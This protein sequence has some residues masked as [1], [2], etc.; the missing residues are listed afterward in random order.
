ME[1]AK[2]LNG[3]TYV[4]DIEKFVRYLR[5]KSDIFVM[6]FN[7]RWPMRCYS[8]CAIAFAGG[9]S[10]EPLRKVGCIHVL[11]IVDLTEFFLVAMLNF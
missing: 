8:P 6:N 5:L 1:I 10:E 3:L 11:P 4:F 9:I 7:T 2:N